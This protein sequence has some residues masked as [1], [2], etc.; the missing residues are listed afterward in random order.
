MPWSYS[1][2]N[3]LR[4]KFISVFP[5][6]LANPQ[7]DDRHV[8]LTPEGRR[9]IESLLPSLPPLTWE[10]YSSADEDEDDNEAPDVLD[11]SS[12]VNVFNIY[13]SHGFVA[14]SQSHFQQHNSE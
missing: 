11:S 12:P 6:P 14:G 7:I 8:L 3:L 10:D 9:H 5:V 4:L 1:L 2:D 13:N